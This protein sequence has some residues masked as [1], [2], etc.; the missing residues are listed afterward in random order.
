MRDTSI[1]K[2]ERYFTLDIHRGDHKDEEYSSRVELGHTDSELYFLVQS[3]N[4]KNIMMDGFQTQYDRVIN[5]G[6]KRPEEFDTILNCISQDLESPSGTTV[7]GQIDELKGEYKEV[8]QDEV[9]KKFNNIKIEINDFGLHLHAFA[10]DEYLDQ[11]L[12]PSSE[13]MNDGEF[14]EGNELRRLSEMLKSIRSS[15]VET[16]TKSP[17]AIPDSELDPVIDG[18]FHS[19]I[20]DKK[21]GHEIIKHVED[22]DAC[23]T[24]GILQPALGSYIHAIEWGAI[25]Y[26][27]SE[28]GVDII[29]DEKNGQYYNFAK[30]NRSILEEL[31]DHVEIDQKTVSKIKSMNSAERRW[32]AHHK[33]GETLPDEVKAVRARLGTFLKT[34]FKSDTGED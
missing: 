2:L 32:M 7:S 24:Q 16:R 14:S 13:E 28:A 25:T 11:V 9:E 8:Q 4:R 21:Y 29:E 3:K 17:Y 27:E 10:G 12:I 23:L 6:S 31:T 1:M 22:G 34:L 18:S 5:F 33:S 30:G 19:S 15:Y 20:V 26:L